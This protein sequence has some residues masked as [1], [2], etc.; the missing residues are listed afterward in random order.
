[1]ISS[2][3]WTFTNP[4]PRR[5][6]ITLSKVNLVAGWVSLVIT[7]FTAGD[8]RKQV[9]HWHREFIC[10]LL[11][12]E[13]KVFEIQLFVIQ[14][15]HLDIKDKWQLAMSDLIANISG[16]KLVNLLL[17]SWIMTV[18]RFE[19]NVLTQN[20]EM[21]LRWSNWRQRVTPVVILRLRGA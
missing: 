12:L 15:W 19:G 17:L 9:P 21:V 8:K 6:C 4:K 11:A 13:G 7:R 18:M 1:M 10:F 3:G 5:I 20:V 16:L 14:S 2:R